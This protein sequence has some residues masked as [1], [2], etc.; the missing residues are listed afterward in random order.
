MKYNFNTESIENKMYLLERFN[1]KLD[2]YKKQKDEALKEIKKSSLA[3][4]GLKKRIKEEKNLIQYEL[5]QQ[6]LEQ[7][8]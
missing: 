7:K 8:K 2:Y 4:K 5:I 1:S 3:I 6:E